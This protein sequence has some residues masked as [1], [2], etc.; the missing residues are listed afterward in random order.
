MFRYIY[1]VLHT[2]F[3]SLLSIFLAIFWGKIPKISAY[4]FGQHSHNNGV[5]DITDDDY[6]K[7]SL[8]RNVSNDCKKL[9]IQEFINYLHDKEEFRNVVSDINFPIFNGK[10]IIGNTSSY[11][12]ITE[13]NDLRNL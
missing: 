5:F 4:H 13:I 6:I 7:T 12:V 3:F 9:I 1:N 11:S 10:K 2:V 8:P